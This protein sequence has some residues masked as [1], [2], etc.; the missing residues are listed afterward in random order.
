MVACDRRKPRPQ[1]L[2]FFE[3]V[4]AQVHADERFLGDV[5]GFGGITKQALAEIANASAVSSI[6]LF[7]ST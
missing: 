5:F 4:H 2:S 6:K 1:V 7:E 3:L